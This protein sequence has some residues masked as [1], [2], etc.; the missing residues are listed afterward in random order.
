MPK[1]I[2]MP[3]VGQDIKTARIVEWYVKEGDRIK[4]GD[5]VAAVESD[6]ATFEV[7]AFDG[8]IIL[9][10]LFSPGDEAVVL[11]PIAFIGESD[12]QNISVPEKSD[13]KPEKI[14]ASSRVLQSDDKPSDAKIL[15]S[16]AARR[17]AKMHHI[18]LFSLK[19]SG[20]NGRIIKRDVL[21]RLHVQEDTAVKEAH[22]ALD[23]NEI[24][25]EIPF[26]K[27]R[28]QIA[29]RMVYSK[30][31]VPHFYLDCDVNVTR[32]LAWRENFN[33]DNKQQVSVNDLLLKATAVTLKKYPRLN[34]HV[35]QERLLLLNRIHIG[36]A[37]SVDDGL[38][39]PVLEDAGQKSLAQISAESAQI[40][41][42]ARMGKIKA[43]AAATFTISNLGMYGINHFL[44]IIN[45]PECA[46]LGAGK[47]EKRFVPFEN[48]T[49]KICSMMN[50][51][52]VCDHRAVDGTYGAQFLAELK[53]I[54]EEGLFTME[55]KV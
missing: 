36:I 29:D 39:V 18:D 33:K 13:Q 30:Q 17:A 3:Q 22:I 44:P 34:A 7:E 45:P 20:P 23:N 31:T 42:K 21:N 5:L 1:P 50:L 16:P 28:R 51:S 46:V 10:R 4:P 32:T 15:I 11:E 19:G 55:D 35:L 38:L 47:I 41:A 54:L 53:K 37:V 6:K 43:S 40:I 24:E 9:R 25:K 14:P 12:E 27:M 48:D 26:S 49:I 52:L 8:G 2:L